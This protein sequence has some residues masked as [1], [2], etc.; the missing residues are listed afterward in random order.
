MTT[1]YEI[2]TRN[3]KKRMVSFWICWV[4][5]TNGGTHYRH[6]TLENAEMEAERLA[7]L[8]DVQGERVYIFECIGICYQELS[9]VKWEVP[10]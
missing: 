8:P 5:G 9:P 3:R 6:Y 1:L 7:G 10:R 2:N 4:E